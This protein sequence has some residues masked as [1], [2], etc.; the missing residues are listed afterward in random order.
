M[1]QGLAGGNMTAYLEGNHHNP[2]GMAA[3]PNGIP[4]SMAM[5][6]PQGGPAGQLQR[7]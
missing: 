2:Y 5:Q 1:Q 3:Q 4:Q 7:R 6:M